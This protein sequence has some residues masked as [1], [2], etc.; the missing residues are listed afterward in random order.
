MPKFAANLGFL[1]TEVDFL[2]RFAAARRAGFRAVEFPFPYAHAHADLKQAAEQAGVE[3]VLFNLLPGDREKGERGIACHPDRVAEFRES[4]ATALGYAKALR[5]PRVNCLAG[6][7]PPGADPGRVRAAIV[8]NLRY[9]AAAFAAAGMTALIEPISRRAVPGFYLNTTAQALDVIREVG[10]ANLKVEYDIFH[11]QAM[12][13]D[14]AKTIEA[15]LAQIGHIQFA[16]A[17]DRHEPGTGEVNFDFLFGWI[18]RLGY[19]GWIGA[20]YAPTRSTVESLG[21]LKRYL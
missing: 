11:M 9:A 13:G 20:E 17:P 14:L 6:I 19:D 16:D 21:W 4:V 7:P 12:E 3:V 8:E 10:A 5:C 2:D 1:F 18:D 15:H